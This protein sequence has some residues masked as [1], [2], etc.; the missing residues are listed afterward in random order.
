MKSELEKVV[1]AAESVREDIAIFLSELVKRKSLSGQEKNVV[2]RIAR[3]MEKVGF[4][5]IVVDGLGN[6]Q[7]RVGNGKTI[8][9]MDAHIDTVDIGDEQNWVVDPLGGEI[10]DGKVYGRG[11]ADQKAG[12]ASLVY[13]MK[14]LKELDLMD[15]F[16]VYVVG[17]VIEEDCDGLCWQYMVKEEGFKPDFVVITEPTN[18]G[19][20]R[21]QRGRIEYKVRT[22]GVSSHASMPERGVNA[23]Y[24]MA[25][26]LSEIERYNDELKKS[27]DP[28]LGKGSIV[29]SDIRSSSPSFNAVADFCEVHIDRRLTVGETEETTKEELYKLAQR[30]GVEIEIEVPTYQAQGFTGLEYSSKKYFPTWLIPEDHLLVKAACETFSSLFRKSPRVGKWNFSTNGVATMG[31]F[32]IPTV[33][34]GPGNEIYAHSPNEFCEIDQLVKAAAFYATFPKIL[35]SKL[36]ER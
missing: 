4:D 10:K 9:A 35:V 32:E 24:K 29:V 31:I 22:R 36:K 17:S 15:D 2:E 1:N 3:E 23:I 34:F 18:L 20:Y 27:A 33:G 25:K 16:T 5:E 19:V 12:M 28:F 11:A 21:G 30:A 14:L 13:G 26:L 7:G 8:I 6:I